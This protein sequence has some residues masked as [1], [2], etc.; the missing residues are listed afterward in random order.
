MINKKLEAAL[1]E[2]YVG[3]HKQ[4]HTSRYKIILDGGEEEHRSSGVLVATSNGSNAWYKSAGGVPFNDPNL[5]FIV[6][7]PFMSR[8]FKPKILHGNIKDKIGFLSTMHD[9][10]AVILDSNYVYDFNHGDT[11]E[12]RKSEK[13]LKVL[14]VKK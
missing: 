9:G 10:G 13:V 14:E 2:V 11:I 4:F 6:R 12:I 8:I 7:E 1:N 5:R 3:A